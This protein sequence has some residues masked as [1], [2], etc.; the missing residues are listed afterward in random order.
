MAVMYGSF[1]NASFV[2]AGLTTLAYFLYT[3]RQ[4]RAAQELQDAKRHDTKHASSKRAQLKNSRATAALAVGGVSPIDRFMR[5]MSGYVSNQA[6]EIGSVRK[7]AGAL[8]VDLSND[9]EFEVANTAIPVTVETQAYGR[10]GTI[11]AWITG[12]CLLMTMMFRTLMTGH[13][14]WVNLYEASIALAGFLIVFYSFFELRYKTRALGVLSAGIAFLLLAFAAWVGTAYDMAVP[15]AYDKITPALQDRPILTIHVSMMIV[16]YAFFI[17]AFVC[18]VMMLAQGD[19]VKARFGWLPSYD[20]ADELGY[21]AVII[22][23]PLLA[24]GVILGAY[25]ANY[26]WGHYWS[27]DPKETSA[28]V[29]WLVYAIYLHARGLRNMR[30]RTMAWL[31]ILGFAATLFTYFGVS[32]I[33]P[34]LHSY[35]GVK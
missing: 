34:G 9:R 4:Y 31:L 30:G 11:L 1:F 29:T 2:L 24:L 23:F 10:L 12:F 7:G 20:A 21:K 27:W 19:G 17:L 32:F 28:L 14:P 35:G 33:I 22:G 5:T 6:N 8:A 26:A 15:L 3:F 18:G 13:A 25:W 16:S